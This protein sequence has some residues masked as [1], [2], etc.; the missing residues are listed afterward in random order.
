V[1]IGLSTRELLRVVG[2]WL[3]VAIATCV[4]F[5]AL[6]RYRLA[7][8]PPLVVGASYLFTVIGGAARQRHYT[9]LLSIL[10]AAAVVAVA[11]MRVPQSPP[12]AAAW[13]ARAV[14]LHRARRMHDALPAYARAESLASALSPGERFAITASHGLALL[15][16]GRPDLAREVYARAREILRAARHCSQLAEL[17]RFLQS[18]SLALPRAG[19]CD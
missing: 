18:R 19:S 11:V 17:D 6:G 8:L 3:A 16:W 10:A 14:A 13:H 1:G 7:V 5:L 2:P 9:R 4:G 15:D 12:S